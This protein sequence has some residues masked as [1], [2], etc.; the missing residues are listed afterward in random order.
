[1]KRILL[2]G[3]S[4]TGQL[5]Q[6][7]DNILAPL[8]EMTLDQVKIEPKEAYSFP[9]DSHDFFD[10]M[11]ETVLERPIELQDIEFKYN[12][13]DLIIIGYQPWFLSPSPPITS[14]FEVAAFVK[15]LENTPVITVIGARNMW[16]SAQ[17][18]LLPK[19]KK[20][21]GRLIA[22][23]PFIDRH[24]N[25]LSALSI[26]HWMLTGNK[27]RKWGLL[28][29]PGVSDEDIQQAGQFGE[30]IAAS[31]QKEQWSGLQE[32][33]LKLGRIDIHPSI[34]LIEKRAK[35]LFYKWAHL[36]VKKGSTDKKRARWISLY[37]YYLI[38]ALF[39]ISPIVLLVY[40]VLFRPI[41]FWKIKA[42]K[43]QLLYMGIGDK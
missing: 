28:P 10:K 3:Y 30:T 5:Y 18:C 14:L 35:P 39:I 16:I 43:Q 29:K 17:K 4:Q 42:D 19:I 21:G 38:F 37:K 20:A 33:C 23:L 41:L 11:P 22:N 24:Q 15:L 36:I 1:M 6:I 13:Y 32:A 40:T 25:L 31:I 7:L 34:M 26:L 2:I 27:T 12:K 9:W 8:Q